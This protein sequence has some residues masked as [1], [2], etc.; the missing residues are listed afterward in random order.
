MPKR[1]GT[2]FVHHAF[3]A[4]WSCLDDIS[5][6]HADREYT[7]GNQHCDGRGHNQ[8][9]EHESQPVVEIL[10]RSC[11]MILLIATAALLF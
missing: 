1:S 2:R 7:G 6:H 5:R 9:G 8:H 11:W 10:C 4:L 3:N